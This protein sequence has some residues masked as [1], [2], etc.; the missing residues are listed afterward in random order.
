MAGPEVGWGRA[1]EETEVMEVLLVR[2][3]PDCWGRC[4]F[5]GIQRQESCM[6]ESKLCS[7]K[8]VTFKELKKKYF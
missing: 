1:Q 6:V 2:E 4:C 7:R 5:Y 8:F 3:T